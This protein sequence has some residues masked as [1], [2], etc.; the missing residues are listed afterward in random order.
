VC[1]VLYKN[2]LLIEELIFTD[3]WNKNETIYS[4]R[5]ITAQ[6]GNFT[7]AYTIEINL[8][9]YDNENFQTADVTKRCEQY[10]INDVL[11]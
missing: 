6:L 11:S 1:T 8:N 2:G 4:E 3:C 9:K 7:A 5:A 10:Y